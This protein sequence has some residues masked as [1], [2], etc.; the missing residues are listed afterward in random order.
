MYQHIFLHR[1]HSH[2]SFHDDEDDPNGDENNDTKLNENAINDVNDDGSHNSSS[3]TSSSIIAAAAT[4]AVVDE[5]RVCLCKYTSMTNSERITCS[6][7]GY[8]SCVKC[9]EE[10]YRQLTPPPIADR[11]GGGGWI[12]PR[13]LSCKVSM[14]VTEVSNSAGLEWIL[15]TI[16]R[17]RIIEDAIA[18]ERN[19]FDATAATVAEM[20]RQRLIASH[21]AR[22]RHEIHG[23]VEALTDAAALGLQSTSSS[24]VVESLSSSHHHPDSIP[25]PVPS[26]SGGD[27]VAIAADDGGDKIS[28]LRAAILAHLTVLCKPSSSASQ[29]RH[30]HRDAARALLRSVS[31]LGVE[32]CASAASRVLLAGIRIDGGDGDGC[33]A[34]ADASEL[35]ICEARRTLLLRSNLA[36]TVERVVNA[37][38]HTLFTRELGSVA[39]VIV[40]CCAMHLFSKHQHP[41]TSDHHHHLLF[42]ASSVSDAVVAVVTRRT[43]TTPS[44][45]SFGLSSSSPADSNTTKA[46]IA[47]RCGVC[48][49]GFM[50][51]TNTTVV[52]RCVVCDAVEC[53]KCHQPREG[54][55]GVEMH[56]CDTAN[57]ATVEAL[58][59]ISKPCPNCGVLIE[60]VDGCAHM[61]CTQCSH[62]FDWNT[63]KLQRF[64]TNPDYRVW[65]STI[66]ERTGHRHR[67]LDGDDGDID[68]IPDDEVEAIRAATDASIVGEDGLRADERLDQICAIFASAQR[69]SS[70]SRHSSGGAAPHEKHND[71]GRKALISFAKCIGA[72][73]RLIHSCVESLHALDD[74]VRERVSFM[75]ADISEDRWNRRV[76]RMALKNHI[77]KHIISNLV[78]FSNGA[79]QAI[80]VVGSSHTNNSAAAAA[81]VG[82]RLASLAA[83]VN[84]SISALF[85]IGAMSKTRAKMRRVIRHSSASPSS[86]AKRRRSKSAVMLE[87]TTVTEQE[88]H[89]WVSESIDVS[90]V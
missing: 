20:M 4:V 7:C 12:L 27:G 70:A 32:V 34:A 5:C 6:R 43:K 89:A 90:T 40:E 1:H 62:P 30:H 69:S 72:V 51:Y 60:R 17:R 74:F 38:P 25:P 23:A 82:L 73:D 52:I 64:N 67:H 53:A 44:S 21:M 8:V 49:R 57:V 45:A 55:G 68:E 50:Y 66:R 14:T 41:S 47:K 54:G 15:H 35:P 24:I 81:V 46:M 19:L 10:Y 33:G 56:V 58:R 13:C 42:D 29:Q 79:L 87:M 16:A 75:M 80:R 88:L 77:Y 78:E 28:S 18:R 2:S 37:I 86:A 59:E 11:G 48:R 39:D 65:I 85:T 9:V 61:F 84:S 36:D 71:G 76:A 31:E 63:M 83:N 22:L 26:D 3:F